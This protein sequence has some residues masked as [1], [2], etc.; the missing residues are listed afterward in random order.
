MVAFYRRRLAA[1]NQEIRSES[2]KLTPLQEELQK[3]ERE[4]Q[5]LNRG[6]QAGKYQADVVV[7]LSAPGTLTLDLTYVVMGPHWSPHY[8]LR[9]DSKNA[10]MQVAYQAMVS[11]STGE[12]WNNVE[13]TLSTAQPRAGA[14]HPDLQPWRIDVY[15]QPSATYSAPRKSAGRMMRPSAAPAMAPKMAMMEEAAAAP[16]PEMAVAQATVEN[17]ASSV[18]FAAGGKHTV[19]GNNQP[20]RITVAVLDFPAVFRYS[21]VPK[22]VASAFLQ[23]KIKNESNYP[24]LAGG[25]SVF[26]DN[27]FVANGDLKTIAPGEAFEAFLGVDEGMKVEHKF[28][29]RKEQKEGVFGGRVKWLYE[30]RI[31]LTS[32]KAQTHD[33]VVKDQIPLTGHADIQV[34]LLEPAVRDGDEKLKKDNQNALEWHYRIEPGQSIEIPLKFTITYPKEM[35][36]IGL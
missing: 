20:H 14:Q 18:V 29:S 6:L 5:N 8:D 13:L 22:L 9:A 25:T 1:L 15:R 24:L 26:L 28:I 33:L 36:V 10:K 3:V 17:Q 21:A 2:N 7:D 35:Q 31:K 32:R 16:A 4:I 12:D 34:E 27:A 30:Y 19:A 11:Q 23:A